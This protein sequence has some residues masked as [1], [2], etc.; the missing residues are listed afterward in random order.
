MSTITKP[1]FDLPLAWNWNEHPGMV[2]ALSIQQ[3]YAS[4]VAERYKTI[5]IRTY[6]T[7]YRGPLLIHAGKLWYGQE[8]SGKEA[9]RRA[10]VAA[11]QT[12]ERLEMYP[13]IEDMEEKIYPRGVL[14]GVG[15]L[16][17]SGRFTAE[18][19]ERRRADHLSDA[20]FHE[21]FCGWQ[22]DGAFLFDL[23][24]PYNGAL[25]IFPAPFK[26]LPARVQQLFTEFVK[27]V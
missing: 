26:I 19:W 2:P 22:F 16:V 17:E 4:F 8:G 27:G 1:K 25:G 14:L 20:D 13:L 7:R 21:K 18:S 10:W 5:E 24:L 6:T 11:C 23:P 12:T 15:R 9:E 3:P